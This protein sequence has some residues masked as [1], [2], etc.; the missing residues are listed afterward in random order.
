MHSLDSYWIFKLFFLFTNYGF[1]V[2]AKIGKNPIEVGKSK[3]TT[4]DGIVLL[5]EMS[6]EDYIYSGISICL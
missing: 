4:V 3:K 5:P 6:R 2:T 1:L